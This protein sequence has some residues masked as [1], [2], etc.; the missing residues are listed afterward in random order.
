M[1]AATPLSK[2]GFL[3]T[4]ISSRNQWRDG[5]VIAQGFGSFGLALAKISAQTE[6]AS[7]LRYNRNL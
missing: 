1:G 4:Q 3:H 5:I 6:R 2:Y 7:V